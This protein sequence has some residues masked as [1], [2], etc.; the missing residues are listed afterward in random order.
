MNEDGGL[1]GTEQPMETNGGVSPVVQLDGWEILVEHFS[2]SPRGEPIT[3]AINSH[4]GTVRACLDKESL[5]LEPMNL[6]F[7]F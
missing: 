2:L 3:T 7:S 4:W 5:T 6:T 1:L